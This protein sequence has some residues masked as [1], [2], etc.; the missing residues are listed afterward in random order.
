MRSEKFRDWGCGFLVVSPWS[1]QRKNMLTSAC[2]WTHREAR[3][4]CLVRHSGCCHCFIWHKE[5]AAFWN[6][7]VYKHLWFRQLDANTALSLYYSLALSSQR[8]TRFRFFVMTM[9]W[10]SW[11]NWLVNGVMTT[12]Q[13]FVLNIN[14]RM[15]STWWTDERYLGCVWLTH[16]VFSCQI[17]FTSIWDDRQSSRFVHLACEACCLMEPR[18]RR[19][20]RLQAQHLLVLSNAGVDVCDCDFTAASWR[21]FSHLAWSSLC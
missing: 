5:L 13:L 16:W 18:I 11:H 15:S 4:R 1:S 6:S 17:T 7:L 20:A 3:L 19:N 2:Q 14:L 10:I 9:F 12:I 21:S 8:A